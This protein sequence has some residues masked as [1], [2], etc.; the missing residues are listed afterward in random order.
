M[1]KL[2]TVSAVLLL[3]APAVAQDGATDRLKINASAPVVARSE[4]FIDAP[5]AAVWAVLTDFDSWTRYMPEFASAR[6]DGP[7]APGSVLHWEPQGQVVENR[8]WWRSRTNAFW[9]G[10][11]PTAPSMSGS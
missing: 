3:A 1:N 5:Q 2:I 10:T 11:A 7:L 9:F 4:L 6:L 8:V